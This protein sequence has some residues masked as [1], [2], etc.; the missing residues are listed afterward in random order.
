MDLNLNLNTPD[1]DRCFDANLLVENVSN[2]RTKAEA[3]LV[4][5]KEVV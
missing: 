5:K 2:T 1:S 4:D 3:L